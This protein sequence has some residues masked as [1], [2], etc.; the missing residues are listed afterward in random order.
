MVVVLINI[1]FLSNGPTLSKFFNDLEKDGLSGKLS[2]KLD[3]K[4][5]AKTRTTLVTN[6]IAELD[7]RTS[8]VSGEFTSATEVANFRYWPLHGKPEV[9]GK[10]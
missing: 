3:P 6:I 1:V 10:K 5:F 2:G 9:T 8:D 7:K 4:E